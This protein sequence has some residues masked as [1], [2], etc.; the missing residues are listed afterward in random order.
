M[1]K[2]EQEAIDRYLAADTASDLV[3]RAARYIGEPLQ[4]PDQD[5][6]IHARCDAVTA[7]VPRLADSQDVRWAFDE[8]RRLA[9]AAPAAD[10]HRSR[11]WYLGPIPAWTAAGVLAIALSVSQLSGP[12]SGPLPDEASPV[13]PNVTN[14]TVAPI[15]LSADLVRAVADI[16]PVVMLANE[17]VVDGRSIAVLPFGGNPD[18]ES[19]DTATR[20][21]EAIYE[22]VIRQL[23]AVPGLYVIDTATAAIYSNSSLSPE[24]IALQLGVR[25]VVEG[26]VDAINGDVRFDLRITD[27]SAN[28]AFD[29][30]IERPT[31][32]LT[33]LQSDIAAS[34]LT[35]LVPVQADEIL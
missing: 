1:T 14:I 17:T 5:E 21:A 31:A 23:S 30:S 28:D 9:R 27:A 34:V 6:A 7:L 20:A 3:N 12:S 10:A 19:L 25:G 26:R 33:L 11:P 32:E 22:Q 18:A 4:G 15:V 16:E 35:A 8:A 2:T 24:E 13:E 29:R